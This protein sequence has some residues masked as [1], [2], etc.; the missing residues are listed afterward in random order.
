M[1]QL[2]D[3][4]KKI[5]EPRFPSDY[6]HL[7]MCD[8]LY[9]NEHFENSKEIEFNEEKW[10]VH[11]FLGNQRTMVHILLKRH[12]NLQIKLNKPK[13]QAKP[14]KAKLEIRRNQIRQKNV[15]KLF[16]WNKNCIIQIKKKLYKFGLL[17]EILFYKN[18]WYPDT[19]KLHLAL[20]K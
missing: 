17:V 16:S 13:N 7:L 3:C 20:F 19:L 6:V 12:I 11:I 1:S 2:S 15:K 9:V 10:Q 4:E 5:F 8:D 14:N 18:D